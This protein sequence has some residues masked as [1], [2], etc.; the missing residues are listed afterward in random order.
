MI[1]DV[2]MALSILWFFAFSG[3]CVYVRAIGRKSA[4]NGQVIGKLIWHWGETVIIA[5]VCTSIGT[6]SIICANWIIKYLP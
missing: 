5:T 4:D 2:L 3:Y 6:L 1:F